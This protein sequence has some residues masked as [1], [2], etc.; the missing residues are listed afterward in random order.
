MKTLVLWVSLVGLSCTPALAMDMQEA[1][2]KA[3]SHNPQ[4]Q[5]FLALEGAA[6]SR[7]DKANAPFWPSLN[8]GYVYWNGEQ[9]PVHDEDDA[10]VVS[11]SVRYN[12]FN[13]GSDWFRRHEANYLATA[14]EYQ[15]QGVVADT[16]LAVK[17]AY[18]QVLRA[19]R[20]VVTEQKSVELLARQKYDSELRLREGLIARNDLLRVGVDLS[21]AQQRL[22]RAEGNLVNTR[23][24]LVR[25]LGLPNAK[26]DSLKDLELRP[27]LP[28]QSFPELQ[29]EMFEARSELR[30]LHNLLA[31]ERAGRK[32]VFG[33]YLP[34]LD[35]A[36][37]YDRFGNGTI[38]E[39]SDSAYNT[40]TRVTV[41][42]IWTPFSGFDTTHELAARDQEIRARYQEI[43]ATEEQLTR[44]L[45]FALEELRV[46]QGNLATAE[47]SVIQA[48]ENYRVNLNRYK[49]QIAT[50]VDL[51][52]AQEYLTRSR[53]EKVRAFYDF[54]LADV[55]LER[56]LERGARLSE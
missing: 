40:D 44:Q 20:S 8:A 17:G 51:L 47:N 50:T 22:M 30:F 5:Q 6:G 9:D 21:T 15:R 32:A 3:L 39:P 36:L 29:N 56:V 31:A 52:D 10:S 28:P 1:V 4:I 41:E 23:N 2:A 26:V 13:G 14:A 54:H 37:S 38:P 33:D 16:V 46:A 53:N 24:E 43:R 42:M 12:L 48:E 25:V 27:E 35:M 45:R 34:D 7:A 11:A 19:Q 18:I 49:A 55:A